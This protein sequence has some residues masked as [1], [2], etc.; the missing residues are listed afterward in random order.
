MAS[1]FQIGIY[2]LFPPVVSAA[3]VVASRVVFLGVTGVSSGRINLK[4]TRLYVS[5]INSKKTLKSKALKIGI[6]HLVWDSTYSEAC[7]LTGVYIGCKYLSGNN[8]PRIK[9][10]R[11]K[12]F[13]DRYLLP[14]T[15][16][17]FSSVCCSLSR[18]LSTDKWAIDQCGRFP[19]D[20]PA[21][22]ARRRHLSPCYTLSAFHDIQLATVQR[23]KCWSIV[24]VTFGILVS[25]TN[26]VSK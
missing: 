23:L 11:V 17:W 1:C 6:S 15:A 8:L 24:T 19:T 14:M 22:S 21:V 13:P 9:L 10:I 12:L 2:T 3:F 18:W 25:K 7:V 26:L 5:N 4:R 20:L 16:Y